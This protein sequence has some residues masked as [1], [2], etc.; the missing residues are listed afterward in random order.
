MTLHVNNVRVGII[1]SRTVGNN[2]VTDKKRNAQ[3]KVVK[4]N[5]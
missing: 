1:L 2:K 5:D 3:D 4:M